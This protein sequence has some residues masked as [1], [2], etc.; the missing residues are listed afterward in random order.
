LCVLVLYL[1]RWNPATVTNA[2]N[3]FA[4]CIY[5][6]DQLQY[7]LVAAQ[8][9]GCKAAGDDQ[10]FERTSLRCLF[11]TD[12][13][14]HLQPMVTTHLFIREANHNGP[15]PFLPQSHERNP[16]LQ[17]FYLLSEEVSNRFSL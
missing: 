3:D 4:L 7:P 8:P 17:I 1:P 16:E 6:T 15:G 11:N 2:G 9:V 12:I 5:L 14:R 13:R 10:S